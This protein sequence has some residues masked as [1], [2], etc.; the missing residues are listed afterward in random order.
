MWKVYEVGYGWDK[1]WRWRLCRLCLTCFPPLFLFSFCLLTASV[2]ASSVLTRIKSTGSIRRMGGWGQMPSSWH[3]YDI[4]PSLFF[5]SSILP[6]VWFS[7]TAV[8]RFCLCFSF[9]YLVR[10]HNPHPILSI[11]K[12]FVTKS[13]WKGGLGYPSRIRLREGVRYTSRITYETRCLLDSGYGGCGKCEC[14]GNKGKWAEYKDGIDGTD[15]GFD[16][17]IN[18]VL[19]LLYLLFEQYDLEFTSLWFF[20][21]FV[22]QFDFL[23]KCN[24]IIHPIVKLSA[25]ELHTCR[26]KERGD[27]NMAEHHSPWPNI[28]IVVFYSE[29]VTTHKT[30]RLAPILPS[31]HAR[32]SGAFSVPRFG[33]G[34]RKLEK[35]AAAQGRKEGKNAPQSHCAF[36]LRSQIH[37]L[38]W[39]TAAEAGTGTTSKAGIEETKNRRN[40]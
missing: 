11:A 7:T 6:I 19:L 22:F 5:C 16:V 40:H 38:M 35:L 14:H 28:N 10:P 2:N 25:V 36:L 32:A 34:A 17:I 31:A 4:S 27:S 18:F 26:F 39:I 24:Q 29:T 20:Q 21:F 37:K 8:L 1:T 13:I 15:G 9:F 33:V 30:H 12:S 3:P 23:E